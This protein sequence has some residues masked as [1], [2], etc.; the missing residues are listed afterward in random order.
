MPWQIKWDSTTIELT[1]DP[2]SVIDDNPAKTHEI[3]YPSDLPILVGFGRKARKL[4]IE[5]ILFDPAKTKS[6]IET[7]IIDP[8]RSRIGKTVTLAQTTLYD[9]IWLLDNVV[10]KEEKGFT[11]SFRYQMVFLQGSSYVVL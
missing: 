9:G 5:G 8:L 1:Q 6:Q 2:S 4:T 11:K 10:P 3:D 7:D